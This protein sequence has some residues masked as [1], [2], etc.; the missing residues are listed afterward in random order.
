[1]GKSNNE[2]TYQATL[3]TESKAAESLLKKLKWC[4]YVGVLAAI[5]II[6]AYVTNFSPEMSKNPADWGV[7]GDYV[8][9][10]LNP[11]FSFLSL[12]ALFATFTLQVREFRISA[13][14]L[15]N[16]TNALIQQNLDQKTKN[17]ESTFFQL[18][19][20]HNEVVNSIDLVS[21]VNVVT[22]GRDCFRVFL[23]RLDA[24]LQESGGDKSYEAFKIHYDLFYIEH[25]HE[26]GHYFRQLYTLIKFVDHTEGIDKKF[27]TNIVR[28]QL[29]GQELSLLFYNCLS[30]WGSQKFKPFVE[31][32]SLLKTMPRAVLPDDE[33]LHQFSPMAFG[34]NYPEPLL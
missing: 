8:G 18:L 9:G 23:N 22:R 10:L 16:S 26:I 7:F 19:K 11:A 21:K 25:E 24:G 5:F 31:R 12:V 27:Y 17:F 20:L 32:Y 13:N 2:F 15:K 34:G 28:A 30:D 14:E 29:S 1:M 6:G 33:L 3:D 4:A